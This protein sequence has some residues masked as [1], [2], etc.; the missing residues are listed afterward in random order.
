MAPKGGAKAD[1]T[2]KGGAKGKKG[3]EAEAEVST[4]A[5]PVASRPAPIYY[6][7]LAAAHAPWY[8]KEGFKEMT[9]TWETSSVPWLRV[10]PRARE[11]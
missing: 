4:G 11:P 7:H 10:E 6:T 5:T 3:K 1:A 2:P 9:D 8:E